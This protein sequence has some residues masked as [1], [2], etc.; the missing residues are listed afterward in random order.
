MLDKYWKHFKSGT[1][2]R[3][4]AS[5]GA[6]DK[7]EIDL[8][9]ENIRKMTAGFVLWL[10]EQR[11]VAPEQMTISVGHDSRISAD[12]IQADVVQV[13]TSAGCHVLCCGLASTPSMFMTTVDLHCTGAVQI[14]A[15]HHPFFRN[16]LK[17]FTRDGGLE[18]SDIEAILEH[19]QNGDTLPEKH[20]M[21]EQVDYM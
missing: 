1:D 2:I 20:G 16:G 15:S 12:R 13:L 6:P 17:F 5:A 21:A 10:A 14:T 3:G 18:G 19:A 9:D 4:I 8:T 11:A 7:R